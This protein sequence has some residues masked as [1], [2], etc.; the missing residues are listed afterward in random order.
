MYVSPRDLWNVTIILPG[1]KLTSIVVVK[2]RIESR[3]IDRYI[4]RINNS[5]P[6]GCG[7]I[8]TLA[9]TRCWEIGILK[10]SNDGEWNGSIRV[11]LIVAIGC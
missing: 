8:T 10:P 2:E 5:K 1:R 3:A 4:V 9:R 11:R 7:T 6:P